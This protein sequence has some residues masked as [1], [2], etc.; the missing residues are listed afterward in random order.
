MKAWTQL[1]VNF[2][3]SEPIEALRNDNTDTGKEK[4]KVHE[5]KKFH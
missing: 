5:I 4:I 1:I 3:D 2:V